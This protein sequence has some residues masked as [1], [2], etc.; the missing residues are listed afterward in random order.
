MKISPLT[1]TFTATILLL[2]G[3]PTLV[4]GESNI[5]TCYVCRYNNDLPCVRVHVTDATPRMIYHGRTYYFC[6][7]NC[8]KDFTKNPK[9]YLPKTS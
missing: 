9:K 2:V 8:L 7:A 5:G 4:A 3:R 1:L 6:S